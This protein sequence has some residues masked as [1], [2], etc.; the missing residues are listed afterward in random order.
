MEDPAGELRVIS[1][2]S[3][4]EADEQ[5][6]R[7]FELEGLVQQLQRELDTA[8]KGIGETEGAVRV[9]ET[10]NRDLKQWVEE[11]RRENR[12]LRE[13]QRSLEADVEAMR[14]GY[15]QELDSLIRSMQMLEERSLELEK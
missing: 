14:L 13:R 4:E 9:F 6:L 11:V 3:S 12:E 10:E 15:E 2:R 5:E 7:M 8:T 1:R